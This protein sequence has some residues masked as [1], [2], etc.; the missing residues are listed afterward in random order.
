MIDTATLT[1]TRKI[2]LGDA[3]AP[4]VELTPDGGYAYVTVNSGIAKGDTTT[5]EIVTTIDG[6]GGTPLDLSITADGSTLVT[7]NGKDILT[8]DFADNSIPNTF[9][10]YGNASVVAPGIGSVAVTPD[11]RTVYAIASWFPS[12]LIVLDTTTGIIEE[13]F[14]IPG[15]AQPVAVSP[16]GND[17][18]VISQNNNVTIITKTP[19]HS[20]PPRHSDH[21][22]SRTPDP[23]N[24]EN[25]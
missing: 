12:Q 22:T 15:S 21:P 18:Y 24:A 8:I 9:T 7:S 16:D 14:D 20:L 1:A 13:R 5:D 17:A 19:N 23:R 4:F 2:A 6:L 11:G 25:I 10:V 3:Q